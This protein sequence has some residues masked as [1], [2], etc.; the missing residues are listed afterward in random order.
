MEGKGERPSSPLLKGAELAAVALQALAH[1][2]KLEVM[3]ASRHP[4]DEEFLD[5]R[6][7]RARPQFGALNSFEPAGRGETEHTHALPHAMAAIVVLLQGRPV[8]TARTALIDGF[9]KPAGVVRHNALRQP[10]LRRYL[11]AASAGGEQRANLG[12]CL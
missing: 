6:D 9:S 12:P 3:P 1:E 10:E 4:G 11:G 5:G 2:T 7:R 8:V